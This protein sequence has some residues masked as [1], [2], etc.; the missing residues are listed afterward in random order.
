MKSAEVFGET[1]ASSERKGKR[2]CMVE[3]KRGLL[4]GGQAPR[5]DEDGEFELSIVLPVRQAEQRLAGT[6][7]CIASWL[8][9]KQRATEVVVVDDASTDATDA[10]ATRWRSYFDG[11]QL[12]RHEVRRGLG[13]AARSGVLA[14]RGRY[15]VIADGELGTPIE[16]VTLI[17]DALA[18]G[19]DV[20]VASNRLEGRGA[21]KPF[22]ERAAETTFMAVSQLVVPV[23]VR[24]SLGGLRGFRR[25]AARKIAERSRVHGAAFSIEWLALA[26]WFGFQV[27]EC[28]ARW[29][30]PGTRTSGLT[31]GRAPGM[32]RD[33]VQTRRR[34]AQDVYRG[35][36]PARQLLEE[37][38]FVRLDRSVRGM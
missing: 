20:A 7:Q 28:P 1:S 14:A 36:L 6:M 24:D 2:I 21:G 34:L 18:S 8:R 5:G 22:L 15:V 25:R 31:A 11:F 29:V 32:L 37:T 35:A 33:L 19:A 3:R 16:N 26:Q 9:Q 23:G 4:A 17:I 38:S 10:A 27:L 12:V 30:Q 13:A